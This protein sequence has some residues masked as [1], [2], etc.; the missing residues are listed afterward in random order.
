MG[1][2]Y[3]IT[4]LVDGKFYIGQTTML[5]SARINKHFTAARKLAR[6]DIPKAISKRGT[7]TK[8]CRAMN[9]HGFDNFSVEVLE[10]MDDD[11]L[12]KAEEQYISEFEAIERG[13][14]LQSG[15]QNSKHCD[16]TRK[17]NN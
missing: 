12:N 14:N 5:L 2:I 16:E 3:K 11:L 10:E 8:L 17:V 4:N 9:D 6:G 7:C 13:Y 1:I 15:G